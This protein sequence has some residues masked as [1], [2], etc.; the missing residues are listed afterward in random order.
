M[1]FKL[2]KDLNLIYILGCIIG[3]PLFAVIFALLGLDIGRMIAYEILG[4]LLFAIV[5]NIIASKRAEKLLKRREDCD[6]T[7][8]I[9]AYEEFLERNSKN[10]NFL[11]INLSAG[12]IDKGDYEKA[13]YILSTVKFAN[14]SNIQILEMKSVYLNNICELYTRLGNKEQAEKYF[15]E[16]QQILYDSKVKY[17]QNVITAHLCRTQK[18]GIEM[19]TASPELRLQYCEI[20]L[21]TADTMLKKVEVEYDFGKAYEDLGDTEKAKEHYGYAA[22]YGG[23]S[24]YCK[25]AKD[26]LENLNNA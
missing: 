16:L 5:L 11:A 12:Y 18:I 15:E 8:F 14:K 23:S 25:K 21:A 2:Y 10:N 1:S 9:E 7:G 20:L 13:E 17:P 6:I 3:I 24:I 19:M 26:R 22:Q 4:I